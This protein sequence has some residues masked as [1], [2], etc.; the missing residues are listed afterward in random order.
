MAGASS[1]SKADQLGD[2]AVDAK[3]TV[4]SKVEDGV[5]KV[6]DGAEKVKQQSKDSFS[7]ASDKVAE[8]TQTSA[9]SSSSSKESIPSASASSSSSSS[10]SSWVPEFLSGARQSKLDAQIQS[11]IKTEIDQLRKKES[12]VR[13]AIDAALE[14]ENAEREKK[15]G[16]S[17]EK[18]K[19]GVELRKELEELRSRL[20]KVA[21]KSKR[22][23]PG[24]KEIQ[25]AREE[26]VKCYK[27]NPERTLDCWQQAQAFKQAVAKAEQ[28]FVRA[29]S[30]AGK[31]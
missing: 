27:A 20:G 30:S 17:N 25:K 13:A 11:K 3:N 15:E 4:V 14:A 6:Q 29:Q 12:D 19:S 16:G 26:V 28:A 5:K 10:S 7:A 23:I 24:E 22:E 18:G 2:A 31:A 9:T 8:K 1:S 21:E